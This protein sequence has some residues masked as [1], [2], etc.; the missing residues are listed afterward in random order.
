MKKYKLIWNDFSDPEEYDTEDEVWD[1]IG[2]RWTGY[3]VID[4]D[5]DEYAIQFLPF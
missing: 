2:T 3:Q 1:A 4:T 5:T